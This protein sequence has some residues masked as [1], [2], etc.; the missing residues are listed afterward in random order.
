MKRGRVAATIGLAAAAAAV[1]GV[2]VE[3]RR[4]RLAPY[5]L[6]LPRW[7]SDLDGLRVAVVGDVHLGAPAVSLARFDALVARVVDAAPD[8][9]LLVGDHFADVH[10]GRHLSANEVA[11]A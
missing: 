6:H 11:A 8:L 10:G 2:Y 3:P 9:V 5:M 7:P 4:L 1:H